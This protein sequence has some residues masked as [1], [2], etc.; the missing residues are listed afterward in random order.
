[1]NEAADIRLRL[2]RLLE[3]ARLRATVAGAGAELLA[4]LDAPVRVTLFG[5]PG[6]GRTRLMN[7]LIGQP[8]LPARLTLPTTRISHGATVA[9]QAILP[10]GSQQRWTGAPFDQIAAAAPLLVEIEVQAPALRELS[11]LRVA[12][13]ASADDQ[14]AAMNWAAGQ[15]DIALWCSLKFDQDEAEIWSGAPETLKDHSYLVITGT[16]AATTAPTEFQSSFILP[17]TATDGGALGKALGLAAARGRQAYLDHALLFLSRYESAQP[18]RPA[19]VAAAP[20]P[21]PASL[22]E[23]TNE[24]AMAAATLADDAPELRPD[25]GKE[26][27]EICGNAVALLRDRARDLSRALPDFGPKPAPR[28]FGHCIETMEALVERITTVDAPELQDL[29]LDTADAITLLQGEGG[30]AQA[31][32]TVTLLLQLRRDLEGRIAA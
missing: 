20:D 32:D 11:L 18:P 3:T 26:V 12:A 15:T 22:P 27:A 23:P 9:A 30:T 4:R 13:E 17:E 1:M 2:G 10:D 6:S 28:V 19:P 24:P 29:V 21:V 5:L 16:G 7:L 25:P 14:F 8:L 31:A